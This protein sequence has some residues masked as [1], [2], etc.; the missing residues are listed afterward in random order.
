MPPM[1]RWHYSG[2]AAGKKCHRWDGGTIAATPR[3]ERNPLAAYGTVDF[4]IHGIRGSPEVL[5]FDLVLVRCSA[6]LL[7]R[8]TGY[9]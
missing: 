1:G 2:Y 7:V 8:N 3:E 6:E 4:V 5:R 9:A